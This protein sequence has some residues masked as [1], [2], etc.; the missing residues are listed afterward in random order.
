MINKELYCGKTKD[1]FSSWKHIDLNNYI[2]GYELQDAV[3]FKDLL[4]EIYIF[5]VEN[6]K[7][8]IYENNNSRLGRKVTKKELVYFLQILLP[9]LMNKFVNN[10]NDNNI[11]KAE[12]LRERIMSGGLNER[13]RESN[14][15]ISKEYNNVRFLILH[16]IP[17]L[18]IGSIQSLKKIFGNLKVY[19][20]F[21]NPNKIPE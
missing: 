19:L 12:R 20:E 21:N 2:E 14:K 5:R 4:S 15:N 13:Y 7:L 8:T 1:M 6:N 18:E 16:R 17:K 9:P 3:L 10:G 11:Y